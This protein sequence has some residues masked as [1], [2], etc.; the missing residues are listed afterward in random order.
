MGPLEHLSYNT[1]NNRILFAI[2]ALLAVAASCGKA[3]NGTSGALTALATPT[4][5]AVAQVNETTLNVTWTDNSSDETG[6]GIY[7]I[8]PGD[9][10]NVQLHGSVGADET[11]YTLVEEDLIAEHSYYVGVRALAADETNN[12][13]LAKVLFKTDAPVDP[14]APKLAIGKVETHDVCIRVA[15]TM[16]NVDRTATVGVCWN[17]AGDPTV[18]DKCQDAALLSENDR[19]ARDQVISNVLLDYGKQYWF[20]AYAKVGKDV[21]YSEA[22]QGGLGSEAEAIMFDWKKESISSLPSSVEVYSYDGLLNG[23]KCK[24]WY[25]IADLSKGDVEFKVNIPSGAQTIDDQAAA[26]G[27]C[28][29]MVNGGYFYNGKNTGLGCVDGVISGGVTAVRGSLKT[30]DEEYNVMY[31]VTRGVFG[32]DSSSKPAVYWTGAGASG[33]NY[34]FDRPLPSVKGE[35]QYGVA[36]TG[37]PTANIDWKPQHAQSAGP[38]LLYDGKCPFDFETTAAGADYYLSNYEIMPYDIFGT[39]VKPDRTAAGYTSDGK[40]ILF[41]VDGRIDES[42]G[43][44]LV[45]LARIMKG[46]G[47]VA[48]VNF[49]GGGSTGMVAGGVHLNDQTGGNRAVVSTLGFYKK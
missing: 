4:N 17:E 13:K 46:L 37:C 44:D 43:A 49:D 14:N 12:S 31:N 2:P 24:A 41:I 22:V 48:A 6:F 11:S 9:I 18:S 7:L 16:E 36:S 21:Y 38:V 29:V 23:R 32:V 19:S 10:E 34:F 47:C 20:R 8:E 28:L 39:G 3:E 5:V 45:E 42:D 26:A 33:D 27:N 1:M 15:Y 40:V 30:E 35:V 25:A